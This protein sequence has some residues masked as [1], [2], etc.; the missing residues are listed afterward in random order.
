MVRIGEMWGQLLTWS[1]LGQMSN[2]QLEEASF[3]LWGHAQGELLKQ[4]DVFLNSG[5][6]KSCSKLITSKNVGVLIPNLLRVI[7]LL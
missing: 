7:D 6:S 3:G 4:S 5:F 2:A 1:V